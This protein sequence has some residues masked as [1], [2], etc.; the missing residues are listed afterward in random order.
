MSTASAQATTGDQAASVTRIARRRPR[1]GQAP[2]YEALAR[3]MLAAMRQWPG[4]QRGELIPPAEAEGDYHLIS[5]WDSESAL[6]G[7]DDSPERAAILVRM[8]LVAEDAPQYRVLT[9]LEAFFR[10]PV[11]P[12]SMHPPRARMAFVTWLGIFPTAAFYLWFVAPWLADWPFL[13]RTA[14]VT[15]LIVYTMSYG[16]APWLT[17]W[18]RPF[19]HPKS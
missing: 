6:R 12:A 5:R 19:L 11:V 14:L 8:S 10:L 13:L 15:L 1:P 4:F 3:E 17:R 9:G 18:L 16:V 7:W 2:A